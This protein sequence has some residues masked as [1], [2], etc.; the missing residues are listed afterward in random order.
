[1]QQKRWVISKTLIFNL[2][3][4]VALFIQKEY[5]FVIPIDLQGYIVV[6]VNFL[7]RF[8]TKTSLVK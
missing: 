4:A 6:G 7:L 2:V 3:A 1:M 5:G 8:A